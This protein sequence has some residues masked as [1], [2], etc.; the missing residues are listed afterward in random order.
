MTTPATWKI[1]LENFAGPMDLLLYL[2]RKEEVDIHDI[3]IERILDQYMAYLEAIQAVN[4]DDAGE[5]L[6]MASTL[7]VIKS[8]MLLPVEEVDL[9]EELDPATSWCSSCSNT[10]ASRAAPRPSRPAARSRR[11]A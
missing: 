5:F 7:M 3:P 6:V 9:D 1:D 10:S 2:I 8:K 4:L 11:G